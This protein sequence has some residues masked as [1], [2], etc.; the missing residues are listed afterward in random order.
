MRNQLVIK[1][2]LTHIIVLWSELIN[3]GIRYKLVDSS[4]VTRLSE[5]FSN[6]KF[7]TKAC[8]KF[9]CYQVG[10]CLI[11]AVLCLTLSISVPSL[12]VVCQQPCEFTVSNTK[13][14]P[15]TYRNPRKLNIANYRNLLES[16]LATTEFDFPLTPIHQIDSL[17][18]SIDATAQKI[19][20]IIT[21]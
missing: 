15:P 8:S 21:D 10:C 13:I 7:C 17:S 20:T 19:T 12:S 3:L 5:Q 11:F 6:T 16:K 14:T 1:V 9:K 4:R 2:A 18:E